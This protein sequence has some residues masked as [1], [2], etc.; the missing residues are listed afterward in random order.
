MDLVHL[1]PLLDHVP[2]IGAVLTALLLAWA[3]P[4]DRTGIGE[5]SF[6]LLGLPGAVAIAEEAREERGERP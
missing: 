2:V 4:R 1:H 5:V 6:G 3:L